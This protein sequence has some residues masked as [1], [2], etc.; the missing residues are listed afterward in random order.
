MTVNIG[1]VSYGAAAV[2]FALLTALFLISWRGK[3]QG[4]LLAAAAGMS[5]AWAGVIAYGLAQGA[6]IAP[7]FTALEFA[8][9]GLWLAFLYKLLELRAAQADERPR[10]FLRRAFRI[11]LLAA[12]AVAGL[13][14]ALVTLPAGS[15]PYIVASWGP[16]VSVAG[17]IALSLAG[18]A[19][20]EQL[21]RNSSD[22]QRWAIKYFCLG[23]G[24]L[25]AY[26]FYLYSEG[27]L[28]KHINETVWVSRG[29]V[30][31]FV[32]PLLAVSAARNPDWS[33]DVFVSRRMVFH[34][35]TL[36]GAGVYLLLMA[37]AGYYLRYFGGTWGG[38]L[39]S[40]FFFGALVILAVVVFSGSM[41]AKLKVF[42]SKHFFSYKYDY[43]EEWLQFTR[44]LSEGEPGVA[45]R[46]RSLRAVAGLVDSPGAALWMA[47]EDGSFAPAAQWNFSGTWEAADADSS[48]CRF[49]RERQWVINLAEYADS[50][51]LYGDLELPAWLD[52]ARE[53][54]LVVPLIMHEALIGFMVLAKP[55]TERGFNWEDSDLL[56]TAGRQAAVHLAQIGA[57]EALNQARQFE[58]FNR[59]SAFVVHDLKN[60]IAQL[61]LTLKNAEKHKHNPEFQEDMLATVNHATQKMTRMLSQLRAGY[62]TAQGAGL[63]NLAELLA[64]VVADKKQYRPTPAFVPA[65]EDVWV[66]AE[67]ERLAR[68]LGHLVQNAIE[69]TAETGVVE[70]SLATEAGQ[71][72]VRVRDNG[73][74]MNE[75]FVRNQLFRPFAST[76][77]AGMG[78]GAYECREYVRELKGDIRVESSPGM[79]TT[80]TVSLPAHARK[81]N[82]D[83]EMPL[84]GVI[85]G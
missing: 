56:K 63:V 41:R 62:Q 74:G 75:S 26:D 69:A 8:R 84:Q 66:L 11:G 4:G 37:A 19:I 46:E 50:P 25:F 57:M 20:I 21:Y 82:A 58:S 30:N 44:T 73:K 60:V 83:S 59:F 34:T 79:G 35:T 53:A 18:I 78:I 85:G 2:A 77:S 5:T 67:R 65:G 47:Q 64:A 27:L 45:V 54:W 52:G 51:D 31:A 33:L 80:F 1:T 13:S 68:V 12:L 29:I 14:I 24:A 81:T 16:T 72:V 7:L 9:D 40:V 32:V 3:I 42:V 22:T 43:R 39:Q 38:V 17:L 76:K 28:F 36:L 70:V 10:R 23:L 6:A 61:S 49:L 55:R 15:V 48:L 71:A